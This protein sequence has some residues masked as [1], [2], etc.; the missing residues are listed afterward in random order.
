MR[1][2]SKKV[3]V[4]RVEVA[5]ADYVSS[6]VMSDSE[7]TLKKRRTTSLSVDTPERPASQPPLIMKFA[8]DVDSNRLTVK[9]VTVDLGE[10][11]PEATTEDAALPNRHKG[12][13]RLS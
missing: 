1:R 7:V 5:A 11:A 2:R 10:T 8:R 12:G 13:N 4:I 6:E 3:G 9:S